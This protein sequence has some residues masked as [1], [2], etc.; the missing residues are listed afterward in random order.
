[1]P[2]L[3]RTLAPFIFL[4]LVV[5]GCAAPTRPAYHGETFA[6]ESPFEHRSPWAAPSI[7]ESGQRAL[8]S[9]GYQVD[10]SKKL[11]IQGNKFFQPVQNHHMELSITLSCLP[12][13]GGS[14]LYASARQTH[15]ELKARSA[16]AAVSLTG[17]GS[18]ALPWL[19][20]GDTLIK[21]GEE[22]V[23][24]PDFYRRFFALLESIEPEDETENPAQ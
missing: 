19:A 4:T 12:A 20:E 10:A 11:R 7:C 14:V 16:S 3:S 23:S 2:K 18:I 8:L 21:I 17:L 13:N 1:M 15:Y 5:A 6:A 24:D 22:T 9:Q